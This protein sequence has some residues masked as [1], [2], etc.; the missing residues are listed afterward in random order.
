MS[1]SRA[2][3]CWII[4]TYY[5]FVAFH[6]FLLM[7]QGSYWAIDNNPP[8]D[9]IPV[10][11]MK[12]KRKPDEYEV[13]TRYNSCCSLCCLLLVCGSAELCNPKRKGKCFKATNYCVL[14]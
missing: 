12:R 13:C 9:G 1:F 8:D 4:I 14:T 3:G 11:N 5:I 6:R 7:L 2:C 10:R